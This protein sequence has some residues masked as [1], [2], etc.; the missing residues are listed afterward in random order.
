M[1]WLSRLAERLERW[2][3]F[4]RVRAWLSWRL[5]VVATRPADERDGL[6]DPGGPG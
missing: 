2:P 6:P 1:G 3:R 5:L 4:D